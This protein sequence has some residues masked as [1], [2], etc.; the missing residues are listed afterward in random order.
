MYFFQIAYKFSI[1]YMTMT[2]AYDPWGSGVSGMPSFEPGQL[3]LLTPE[4]TF[5][6]RIQ[7]TLVFLAQLNIHKTIFGHMPD[8]STIVPEKEPR[9]LQY[10]YSHSEMFL[11]NLEANCGDYPRT[12]APHYRYIS[13]ASAHPPEPLP[14]HISEF[15]ADA[16]K[17]IV[18]VSFGSLKAIRLVLPLI[19]DEMMKALGKLEQKVL[20]SYNP[21]DLQKFNV[22]KNVMAVDWL[23]QNDLLG[24]NKTKLFVTHAGE[25]RPNFF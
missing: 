7:N 25:F 10:L 11:V 22:P 8:T 20:F 6:Q 16:S 14:A 3:L 2:A 19:M 9:S 24:H 15:I 18:V 12:S 4:M 21:K 1:P 17:G 23:P 13:G 5:F